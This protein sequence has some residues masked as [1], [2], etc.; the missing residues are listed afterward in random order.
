MSVEIQ[1]SSSSVKAEVNPTSKALR[2][3]IYPVEALGFY[4][5]SAMTGLLSGLAANANIFA[6]RNSHAT[7]L[8]LIQS[9]R[10]ALQTITA[11]TAAQELAARA[12]IGRSYSASAT[13]GTAITAAGTGGLKKRTSYPTS[14]LADARISTTTALTSPGTVTLDAQEVLGFSYFSQTA[15]APAVM[16]G[17]EAVLLFDFESPIVLA[18]NEGIIVQ[19]SEALGAGGTVRATV[20]LSWA[21]VSSYP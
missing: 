21:E 9:M 6:F 15:A 11:F 14:A 3:T 18:Q 7:T 20:E 1:G 13:G 8:F 10:V 17:T 5:I 19:S 4:R 12:F 2:T 16:P